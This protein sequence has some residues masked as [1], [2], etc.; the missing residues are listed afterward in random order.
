MGKSSKTQDASAGPVKIIVRRDYDKT[1]ANLTSTRPEDI[2]NA[3]NN[4][5]VQSGSSDNRSSSTGIDNE[6]NWSV[7]NVSTENMFD[8]LS[9]HSDDNAENAEQ[10]PA[11]SK[12]IRLPPIFCYGQSIRDIIHMLESNKIAQDLY[13]LRLQP[14]VVR[15]MTSKREHFD[16]VVATLK[17]HN[18]HYYTHA[19]ADNIPMKI[20]LSGLPLVELN[21]LKA[22]LLENSISPLDVKVLSVSKSKIDQH[23]LYLLYFPKGTI[24]LQE[25][26]KVKSLFNVIVSWRLF[27]RKPQDAVQCHRCQMFGHGLKHCNLPPRCVKC[28]KHHLTSECKLPTK[29]G[30]SRDEDPR[31]SKVK[32][33]NCGENHTANFRGCSA[34]TD[35]LKKQQELRKRQQ[36]KQVQ[37]RP[38]RGANHHREEITNVVQQHRYWGTGSN[39]TQS[40]SYADAIKSTQPTHNGSSA[41]LFT[42]TEFMCLARD[43]YSKLSQCNS[44]LEQFM[45]ISELMLK[46]VYND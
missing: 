4:N 44:K 18:I 15:I 1:K 41:D 7:S 19:T 28:A 36:L 22:E 40:N 45:A 9:E 38:N 43:L 46:Y 39:S 10:P 24:R 34:R 20:V 42:V 27:S 30:L 37:H 35:Y 2:N 25:L 8:V 5:L 13:Q 16:A 32:C 17:K 11:K 3:I 29:A 33:A 31:R 23:A 12:K 14:G 6:H 21:D 26:S